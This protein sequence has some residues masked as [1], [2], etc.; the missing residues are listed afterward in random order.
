MGAGGL[1][2]GLGHRRG[3]AGVGVGGVEGCDAGAEA[4]AGVG[5]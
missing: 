5:V 2:R 4:G 3:G 1:R